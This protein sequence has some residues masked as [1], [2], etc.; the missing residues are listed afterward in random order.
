MPTGFVHIGLHQAKEPIFPG[1]DTY[2]MVQLLKIVGINNPNKVEGLLYDT[3]RQ[4]PLSGD[5]QVF[6]DLKAFALSAIQSNCPIKPDIPPFDIPPIPEELMDCCNCSDIALI[7]KKSLQSMR[8]SI[9]IPIVSCELADDKW[10]PKVAYKKLEIF[11]VNA[12]T[13]TS[14]AELYRQIATQAR[15]IC[16]S[17]NIV[18]RT[19]EVIGVDEYPASLPS[20]LISKD[21]GFLGN[22][23][24]NPKVEIPNLTKLLGWYIERFDEI[25]GQFEIPIEIKDSD[26]T[27]PGEQPIGIK[28]PNIAESLAEIVT[29]LFTI[30]MNSEV[31]VSMGFRTL[32]ETGQD[33]QQNFI[34][35]KL[36]LSLVDYL[37][38][39]YRETEMDLPMMFTPGKTRFD[40]I[41]QETTLKVAVPEFD[42]KFNF[43]A[44]LMRFRKAASIIDS[45]YF[46]KIDPNGDIKAQILSNLRNLLDG[47][48]SVNGDL[49]KDFEKFV[50]AV[51]VGFTDTPGISDSVNPYG[52]NFKERPRVKDL[53]NN[54]PPTQP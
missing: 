19:S 42:K 44:D 50:T 27:T 53:T 11:A 18:T 24:P 22:L 45:V 36:L 28:L 2:M 26:P 37:G 49:D 23:I 7:L 39:K 46:R 20:S 29:L 51:E 6:T 35:Y 4:R 16:D 52:R 34:S 5:G 15:E 10:T 8:Y 25:M 32:L 13:A 21:E 38:F 3:R 43:E 9:E 31:L 33:K 14:Q 41:L 54:Q 40:E 47:M 30:N 1:S 48:K 17:K 12:A